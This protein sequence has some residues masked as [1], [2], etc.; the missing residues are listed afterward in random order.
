VLPDSVL[1]I[2]DEAIVLD[3]L[4]VALEKRGLAVKTS[5]R[6]AQGLALLKT[7]AFGCMLTD[8]NLPDG[9]GL[10]LIRRARELQPF[11]ACIVITAYPNVE[12]ILEALR[13][14]AVDYLEKPFP[15]MALVQ[16]KVVQAIARQRLAAERDFLARRVQ[17]LQ[18]QRPKEDFASHAHVALLQQALDQARADYERALRHVQAAA[19]AKE[20]AANGRLEAVK[21]RHQK[22]LAA[23]RQGT[24]Q[25]AKVL[26]GHRLPQEVEQPLREVRRALASVLDES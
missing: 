22:A 11:C 7:E 3:V 4:T 18:V 5:T 8:K 26:E 17:E 25:L 13:L 16:E 9:S 1:L 23:L 21:I 24:E 14:G 10:D 12:S 19:Q 15:Q 2:D 20:D 6:A